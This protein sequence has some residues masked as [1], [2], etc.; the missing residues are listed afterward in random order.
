MKEISLKKSIY[1]LCTAYPEL[2]EL[3]K[4]LG[5]VNI[6]KPGMLQSMGKIMTIPKGCRTMK[7]PLEK[8]KEHLTSHG[9]KIID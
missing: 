1:Q 4:E 2:I 5:F 7:I 6:T 3:M 9:F 8:V